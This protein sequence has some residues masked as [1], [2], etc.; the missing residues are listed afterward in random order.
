MV[1]KGQPWLIDFQSGRK[2]PLH[3][4]IASFLWQASAQY[5]DAL[6]A[7]LIEEY[8]DELST[9]I[10]IDRDQ[11]KEELLLFVLF[12]ML[13]VLGAYGL[14]GLYERKTYFLQ[15]IPLAL[16]QIEQL[17]DKGVTKHYP[18]LKSILSQLSQNTNIQL[19]KAY[20]A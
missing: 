5:P 15:S 18:T 14:R 4:D 19:D 7:I 13:Q 6:R 9:L 16:R 1:Y 3:Y 17:I 12:R 20:H 2:G 11:F 8:L 10:A